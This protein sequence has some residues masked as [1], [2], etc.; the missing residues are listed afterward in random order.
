[1]PS[2]WG[3][4]I[5]AGATMIAL[6]PAGC[7]GSSQ[8]PTSAAAAPAPAGPPANVPLPPGASPAA[9]HVFGRVL[10]VGDLP[11]L[12]PQGSRQVGFHAP[13]WVRGEE[14]P[15]AQQA[16]L[17]ARLQRLGFVAGVRE[18]LTPSAGG[19]GEAV[20]IVE[21]FRSARAAQEELAAEAQRLKA[22]GQSEF[23]VPAIP[24]ARGVGGPGGFNVI[25]GDSVYYYLVGAGFP[26]GARRA[27]SQATLAVAARRLYLRVHR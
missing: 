1:M 2:R 17:I 26:P 4:V 21:Q 13:S 20:S 12:Q 18:R 8:K 24:G 9:R 5:G 16:E 15:Q 3:C 22:L 19:P 14:L 27:P 7:G 11:G 25:F 10:H 23:A 6:L